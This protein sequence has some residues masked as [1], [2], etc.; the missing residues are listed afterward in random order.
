LYQRLLDINL[1]VGK[2]FYLKNIIMILF[3][4][5]NFSF[6][7]SSHAWQIRNKLNGTWRLD[8]ESNYAIENWKSISNTTIEGLNCSISKS[9]GDTIFIE[10]LRILKTGEDMFFIS[11]VDHNQYPVAF[12]LMDIKNQLAIFQNEKHDFPQKIIYDLSER[13]KIRAVI[14]GT[15]SKTGKSKRIEFPFIRMIE[16]NK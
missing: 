10:Y 15:D 1:L 6:G 8:N 7:Q 3:I 4:F 9:S 13:D 5:I 16:R 2:E 14:E 11:K 12:Q